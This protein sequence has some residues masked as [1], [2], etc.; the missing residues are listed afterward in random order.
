MSD[1]TEIDV[2]MVVTEDKEMD[3]KGS[4]LRDGGLTD[5]M[6]NQMTVMMTDKGPCLVNIMQRGK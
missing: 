3:Q 1:G 5:Q 4:E 2:R 6:T